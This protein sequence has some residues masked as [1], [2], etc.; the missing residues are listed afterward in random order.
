MKK[1]T[2]KKPVEIVS[3]RLYGIFNLKTRKLIKVSLDQEEIDMEFALSG[4]KNLA[5][6][7]CPV[8]LI[9]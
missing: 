2:T 3:V 7:E 6:C 1:N 8:T 9:F 5:Q 4:D